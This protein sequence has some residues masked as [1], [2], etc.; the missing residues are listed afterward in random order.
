MKSKK[1]N[2]VTASTPEELAKILGI[3]STT[4]AELIG[5]H[6]MQ[7]TPKARRLWEEVPNWARPKI[8]NNVWCS[9]CGGICSIANVEMTVEEGDL[10]L[11][12]IC[13]KCN[14]SVCRVVEQ[15]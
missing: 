7:M 4:D 5:N 3:E 2:Y 12:G 14:D 1:K 6:D 11:R 15:D 9:G 13:T 10:V 8:L